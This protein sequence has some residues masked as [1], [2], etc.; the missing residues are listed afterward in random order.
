MTQFIVC[1]DQETNTVPM[2]KEHKNEQGGM[3]V[4]Q[5]VITGSMGILGD[6]FVFEGYKEDC[7]FA[8]KAKNWRGFQVSGALRF[9]RAEKKPMEKR[10]KRSWKI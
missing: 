3:E 2:Q 4:K 6:R 5:S 7:S 9:L 1:I 10:R 8:E